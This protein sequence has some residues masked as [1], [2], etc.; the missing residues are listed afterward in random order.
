MVERVNQLDSVFGSLSDPTRRDILKKIS[1]KSMSVGEIASY[2]KLTFAAVAKHLG[3]LHRANLI[4]KTRRGKE[5]IVSITPNTLAAAS[6]YL[7]N[8]AQLWENRLTSLDKYLKTI[9]PAAL[10]AP[11]GKKGKK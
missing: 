10:R 5:R 9:S 7:E 1:K 2:Y 3:V 8:Y 6:K 4:I 11:A